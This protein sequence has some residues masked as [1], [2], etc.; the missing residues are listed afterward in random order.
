MKIINIFTLLMKIEELKKDKL[1]PLSTAKALENSC[2]TILDPVVKYYVLRRYFYQ[3]GVRYL[4]LEKYDLIHTQDVLSTV[5]INQIRPANTAL[6][7]T[8]HGCVAHEMKHH[9]NHVQKN[10]KPPT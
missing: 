4:G 2:S 6:V 5:C 7:A 3:L 1:L 9:V 10:P 8:L